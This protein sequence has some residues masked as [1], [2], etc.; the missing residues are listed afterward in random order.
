[1]GISFFC[2]LIN[3]W[4]TRI[5]PVPLHGPLYQKLPSSIISGMAN[6]FK[7]PII[8]LQLQDGY[9]P[10]DTIRQIKWWFQIFIF[11]KIGRYMAFNM[12][13]TYKWL[14]GCISNSFRLCHSLPKEPP[15]DLDHMS[16][17]CCNIIQC[18]FCLCQCPLYHIINCL[19][20]FSGGNL[21]HHT[22]IYRM[23][24]YLRKSHWTALYARFYHGSC[25][26]IAG[27][28]N[29]KYQYIFCM[30]HVHFSLLIKFQFHGPP[31]SCS[32][33]PRKNLANLVHIIIR[34]GKRRAVMGQPELSLVSPLSPEQLPHK[35]SCA[36]I[37]W[38][39]KPFPFL[40]TCPHR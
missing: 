23:G 19:N 3:L 7:F 28:L 20:M 35:R 27:T 13:N 12:V 9:V 37:L 33:S 17:N 8:L 16:P 14:S 11:N 31:V 5:P 34:T 26:F 21:R 25:R 29:C 10:P 4:T 40:R 22:P 38:L 39:W 6:N 32:L 15:P 2:C 36:Y 18:C 1:M 24:C 30:I